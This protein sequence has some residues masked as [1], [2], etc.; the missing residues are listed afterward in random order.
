MKD[1][2]AVGYACMDVY[3][4]LAERYP[5]GNGVDVAV[6][7]ARSGYDAALV[8]AV[9]KDGFGR[10]MLGFCREMEIDATHVHETDDPT[11][12][13]H[14]SLIAGDRVH[15][16]A[17]D[18]AM[19]N[20]SLTRSD[21][22]FI[23]E[24]KYLHTDFFGRIYGMLE[25]FQLAGCKIVFDFSSFLTDKDI[26]MILPYVD[27]G[28]ISAEK[29]DDGTRDFMKEMHRSG[30]KL[31]I[32]TAGSQGAIAYDGGRFYQQEALAPDS[33]VNTVGCGD[34]FLAGFL[35]G[36]MA[37]KSVSECLRLGAENAR[38]IIRKFEPY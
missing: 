33:I 36:D 22:A 6:H 24:Y 7:L 4:N 34:A 23:K 38:E 26:G 15:D 1:F 28:Q 16:K 21:R 2:V 12:Q 13:I 35:R 17:V 18:G 14:M 31:C 32:A 37:G 19:A 5:T 25:E 8:S 30:T 10:E 29:L 20:F 3:D 9:G 27:I 11:A